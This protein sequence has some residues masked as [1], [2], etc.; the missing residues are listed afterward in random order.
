MG[1]LY[2]IV[3]TLVIQNRVIVSQNMDDSLVECR[4]RI[5]FGIPVEDVALGKDGDLRYKGKLVVRHFN[6]ELK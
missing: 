5:L 1:F 6:E 3:A 4:N 2:N